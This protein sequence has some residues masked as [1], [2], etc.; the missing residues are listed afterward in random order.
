MVGVATNDELAQRTWASNWPG[1]LSVSWNKFVP[2]FY[3]AINEVSISLS[4][5]CSMNF[6][7]N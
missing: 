2:V 7:Y 1:Q 4:L 6:E 5:L 3:K